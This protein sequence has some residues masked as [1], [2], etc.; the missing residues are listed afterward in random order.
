[1]ETRRRILATARELFNERGLHRVGVREIARATEMSPGNLAYHFPTKDDLVS[2]LVLELHELNARTAF[3][4]LPEDF[5]LVALYRAAVVGMRNIWTFRFVILSYADAVAASLEL[6]KLEAALWKNRRKRYDEMV[7][8]LGGN[9][10]IDH[11][12]VA[13]RRDLL[14]EQSEMISSGWLN[15]ATLRREHATHQAAILHYAKVGMALLEPH[16]TPR[17]ARQMRRILAGELDA[18][19]WAPGDQPS[20]TPR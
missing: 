12:A 1:M 13:A 17:G 14:Y 5:S 20:A 4:A 15:A 8:R 9:G 3:A 7:D 10:Y 6:Q 11:R 18:E 2:A 16:C 19:A